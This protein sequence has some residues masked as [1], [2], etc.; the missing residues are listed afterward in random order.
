MGGNR[1]GRCLKRKVKVLYLCFIFIP[2]NA[3]SKNFSS[4]FRSVPAILAF[5]TIYGLQKVAFLELN[6][7][8]SPSKQGLGRRFAKTGSLCHVPRHPIEDVT[9][10]HL[11]AQVL[12]LVG[13]AMYRLLDQGEIAAKAAQSGEVGM[14]PH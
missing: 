5:L 11:A 10:I 12:N 9:F 2:S 1:W 6:K 3:G 13:Y 8:R 14:A 4:H 7:D